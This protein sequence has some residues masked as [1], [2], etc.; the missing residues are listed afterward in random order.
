MTRTIALAAT[1]SYKRLLEECTFFEQSPSRSEHVAIKHAPLNDS[2]YSMYICM[3]CEMK[4]RGYFKS[5]GRCM[6]QWRSWNGRI[7]QKSMQITV[8]IACVVP[9][10]YIYPLNWISVLLD[11]MSVVAIVTL[12]SRAVFSDDLYSRTKQMQ[13][14]AY[15]S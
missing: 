8:L 12:I 4:L 10:I 15:V 7:F 13:I 3:Y 1:S 9:R 2:I 14:V 6:Y 5:V 11:V